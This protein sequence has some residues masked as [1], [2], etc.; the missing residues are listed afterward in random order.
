MTT[1]TRAKV[2]NLLA[3]PPRLTSFAIIFT[4]SLSFDQAPPYSSS[5]FV[6]FNVISFVSSLAPAASLLILMNKEAAEVLV[7]VLVLVEVLG[8]KSVI[9]D[10]RLAFCCWK[11]ELEFTRYE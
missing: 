7:L 3:P 6:T 11:L 8:K 10:Y 2:S 1:C 5:K 4:F 9:G